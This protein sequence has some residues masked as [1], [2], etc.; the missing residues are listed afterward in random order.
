MR[1]RIGAGDKCPDRDSLE[2]GG[3]EA[4]AAHK[5]RVHGE[6]EDL[7]HG[8]KPL[9]T[10]DLCRTSEGRSFGDGEVMEEN[11]TLDQMIQDL[12]GGEKGG[13]GIF[14]RLELLIVLSKPAEYP[15]LEGVRDHAVFLE[16]Q[17]DLHGPH[18]RTDFDPPHGRMRV[19]REPQ[20]EPEPKRTNPE[21]T[22]KRPIKAI[23]RRH[24]RKNWRR[25]RPIPT[26]CGVNLY[27]ER[28]CWTTDGWGAARELP[29]MW[30]PLSEKTGIPRI[31]G[32]ER[33]VSHGFEKKQ[34]DGER[35]FHG[36]HEECLADDRS[37]I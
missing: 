24:P 25:P 5:A 30:F 31:R 18:P 8:C 29:W 37:M 16:K 2:G 21:E 23:R 32:R 3:L 34:E 10:D 33:T 11:A 22:A 28:P 20:E 6:T 15:E 26:S 1:W 35:S 13:K 19:S 7:L 17:G 36:L 12:F 14:P 9:V 27:H 4:Q